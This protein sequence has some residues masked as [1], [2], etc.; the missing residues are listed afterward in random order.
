[1]DSWDSFLGDIKRELDDQLWDIP[2]FRGHCNSR[3]GLIPSLY[4][5]KSD[6]PRNKL[7][8]N[9]YTDFKSYRGL[10]SSATNSWELLFEMRHAGLPTRLL[11]W[12]EDFSS[13]LHF[14]LREINWNLNEKRLQPCI[15]VLDPFELNKKFYKTYTIG[16][17]EDLDFQYDEFLGGEIKLKEK[18]ISGPVAFFP[19]RSQQRIFAQKSVFTF[20]GTTTKSLEKLY[21]KCVKRFDIPLDSIEDAKKFLLLSGKDEYSLF[22]DLDGLARM[23]INRYGIKSRY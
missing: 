21:P 2:L 5:I 17:L 14:A 6:L 19:P 11:D 18:G 8:G 23:L 10:S 15:W 13:A 3:W 12:T 16:L 1:M 22:P 4:R 9:L 20:H 7:E